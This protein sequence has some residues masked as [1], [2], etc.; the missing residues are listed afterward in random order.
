[1]AA[2]VSGAL[3]SIG[4]RPFYLGAAT[5]AALAVPVWVAAYSG[6]LSLQPVLPGYLWHGHEMVFGFAPAVIVGFLLTAARTWTGQP[7]LAGGSLATL[8]GL[9]LAARVL[10]LTGPPA[11]AIL[12]DL[13]VLPLA[14]GALAIPLWR[15]RNWRN[16]F[17]VPLLLCLALLAGLHHGAYRGWVAVD[18]LTRAPVAALDLLAILLAV[19]GGRV[20]PAFSANAIP[21][22][23]PRCWPAVDAAAV[24][25]LILIFLLDA[26]GVDGQQADSVLQI[27]CG[28]AG[29]LHLL[30]V[31]G[32]RP[33][34]A[35]GNGLLLAL[36]LG[37]LW[38][39]VHLLLRSVLDGGSGSV[40]PAAT[41]ALGL[42]AMASLML[43]MMTRSALGHTGRALVAGWAELGMFATIHLA[44]VCRVFGPLLWPRMQPAWIAGS[45]VLWALAFALF[46]IRYAPIVTRP[47]LGAPGRS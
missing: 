22:L 8:F 15:S 40:P 17:V 30:R 36:P 3:F 21:G 31:A 24:G 43:A 10:M 14:A 12:L 4:F 35:W 47:R 41:H 45:G 5:F 6:W 1:M 25:L 28:C 13:A 18:W 20:I 9:W 29:A 27:L 11:A 7:T 16:A 32:W 46:A 37:Y 26:S 42:G 39:P 44:A 34:R 2:G 38:L 33:W 23:A 19:I